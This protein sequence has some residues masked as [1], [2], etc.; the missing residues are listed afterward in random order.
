VV[1][2]EGERRRRETDPPR[3]RAGRSG[4]GARRPAS[5]RLTGSAG[6]CVFVLH[7]RGRCWRN[8]PCRDRWYR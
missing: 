4:S 2:G 3:P 7:R 5:R 1:R 6:S 8:Q